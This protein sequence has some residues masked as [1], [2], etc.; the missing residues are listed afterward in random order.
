MVIH[1]LQKYNGILS[2]ILIFLFFSLVLVFERGYHIG[3][4]LLPLLALL[5]FWLPADRDIDYKLP[6]FFII[7]GLLWSLH[8]YLDIF[9]ASD[10]DRYLRIVLAGITLIFLM[11][12]RIN[13]LAIFYGIAFGAFGAFFI[14]VFQK[15][16]LDLPRAKGEFHPIVFGNVS[17]MLGLMALAA[18]LLLIKEK[19]VNYWL[20]ISA[21][22]AGITASFLS[23]SR[24]GWLG[25]PVILLFIF[26][27][28][29]T[30]LSPG[31]I[32]MVFASLIVGITL[33]FA[34]P[35][36]G[37]KERVNSAQMDLTAYFYKNERDSSL[38]ARLEMW[39]S[40]Y[41]IFLENPLTGAGKSNIRDYEEFMIKDRKI[42][43]VVKEYSHAHSDYLDSLS[44]RGLAGF[45]LLLVFYFGNLKL[46][47]DR[48]INSAQPIT[49]ALALMGAVGALCF[50][51]FSLSE[52]LLTKNMGLSFYCFTMIILWAVMDRLYQQECQQKFQ[53]GRELDSQSSQK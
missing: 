41:L 43:E 35:V 32:K 33:V 22:I 36:T 21:A 42:D 8:V 23:G 30:L 53:Q 18:G 40:A 4:L 15:F 52:S 5:F 26:Y 6:L 2:G 10:S 47:N 45:I 3:A 27:H 9:K 38:G 14:A 49:K 25:L 16:I 24:G 13:T 19:K 17:L 44:E 51:N 46:F 1:K 20:M 34:I 28:A 48:V 37:V 12:L 31:K 29:S 7:I 11:K 39:R 50:I